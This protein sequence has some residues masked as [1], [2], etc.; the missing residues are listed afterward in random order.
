[1]KLQTLALKLVVVLALMASNAA[2]A[3]T[4]VAEPFGKTAGGEDVQTFTLKNTKGMSAK[5][6]TRGATLIQL[7]VPD[8]TGKT[9]D[10]VLGFD[11]VAGYE[12]DDN[13][14]FGCTT[15][16]VANRIAKGKF[17]LGGRDYQVAINNEPNALHGGVKRS[18]D[19]VVWAAEP[20][21]N[22][23]GQGVKFR[24]VSPHGEEGYPGALSIVVDYL[25]A[26]DANDL[27]INY[28]ATTD[29][30]TPINLTNH[31]YFNLSGFGSP[32]ILDHEMQLFCDKYTPVDDTLIPTGEIADVAGTPLDFRKATP[33]GERVK[34][35]D[36]ASTIG[37]DHNLIVNGTPGE[38][39]DVAKVMDPKSGRVLH[40]KT[41]E[42][43]VQFYGG[44]FLKGQKGKGG[45]TFAHRSAFCLETQHYPDS[46]NQ[47]EFPN[48]VLKPGE[49]YTHTCVYGF[50]AE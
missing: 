5:V 34:E 8:K 7:H 29:Q 18:L 40:V 37:Y 30:P 9:A 44:N 19:K 6:M 15:G 12:S 31:S 41:T 49:T 32:T 36:N 35:L 3:A 43:A 1:M 45:K 22:D 11:D 10:V 14:Y 13:Q 33:I 47:P 38:L 48:T 28:T 4:P 50:R 20:Y 17:K 2:R 39:R 23:Q 46:I 16:R 24:Y 21:E 42:P 27:T 26:K 25:L